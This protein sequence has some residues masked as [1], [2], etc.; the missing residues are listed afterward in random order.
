MVIRFYIQHTL[1]QRRRVFTNTT[2]LNYGF[3]LFDSRFQ[4]FSAASTYPL[5]T[6]L[7]DG[8]SFPKLLLEQ[9]LW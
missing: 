9:E 6:R 7:K 8:Y 1:S 4:M 3:Y 2:G 5:Q